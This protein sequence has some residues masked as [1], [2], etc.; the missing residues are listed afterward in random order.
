MLSPTSVTQNSILNVIPEVDY[1]RLFENLEIVDLQ[2]KQVLYDVN[3]AIDYVYFPLQAVISLMSVAQNQSTTEVA[4][5]G[6]E[7]VLGVPVFLGSHHTDS[8]AVVLIAGTAARIE[9]RIFQ[10]EAQRP[11]IL[12]ERLLAFTRTH[13]KHLSQ[14]VACKSNHLIQHQLARWLLSVYDRVDGREIPLTQPYIAKLF[15]VRRASITDAAIK[16]QAAGFISYRRG[17][18]LILDPVGLESAACSC[19]QI[20][21]SMF[22]DPHHPSA[23]S[24][25]TVPLLTA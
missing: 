5:L 20:V 6:R 18:I 2:F 22:A 24:H 1:P 16:L 12:R 11:G 15:G 23:T 21:K 8:Q 14:N 3:K 25:P 9:R 17:L 7:G 10:A 13:F 19:Y 4:L